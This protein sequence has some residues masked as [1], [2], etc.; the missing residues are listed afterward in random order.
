MAYATDLDQNRR[1]INLHD[2]RIKTVVPEHFLEQYPDFITFIEKY[3]DFLDSDG[4]FGYD[5]KN[6]Q[7]YKDIESTPKTYLQRLYEEKAP[8]LST[9]LFDDPR[10]TLKILYTLYKIKGTGLSVDFFFRHFYKDAAEQ[11]FPKRQMFIVGESEIGVE[12]NKFIQDSYFYQIYSILIRSGIVPNEWL[13]IY[14][15]LIHPAGFELFAEFVTETVAS[16][17]LIGGSGALGTS[18]YIV[19]DSA[20]ST[21]SISE[22]G[23]ITFSSASSLT[24]VDSDISLRFIVDEPAVNLYDSDEGVPLSLLG[25][26]EYPYMINIQN[27]Y[28]DIKSLLNATSPTFDDSDYIQMSNDYMTFD[29]DEF[30]HYPSVGPDSA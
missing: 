1:P 27:E 13:D 19:L 25:T 21:L 22:T 20:A 16:N 26:I 18:P 23:T 2:T 24:G 29:R 12:S 8:G 7:Y 4:N 6:I 28:P 3:Y 9:E 30:S 14:K 10:I 17:I 11:V 15:R 5:I